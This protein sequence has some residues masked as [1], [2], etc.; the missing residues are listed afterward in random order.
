ME[1]T[2]SGPLDIEG[3]A[4]DELG[5]D[6][7]GGG[8]GGEEIPVC[9]EEAVVMR[10]NEGGMSRRRRMEVYDLMRCKARVYCKVSPEGKI[11]MVDGGRGSPPV[12]GM[13]MLMRTGPRSFRNQSAVVGIFARECGKVEGCRLMVAQSNNLTFCEQVSHNLRVTRVT[14]F[15]YYLMRYY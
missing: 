8:G 13:T 4:H 15:S 6:G 10:H 2:F 12:I 7:G 14:R 1:A 11:A 5:G 3:F 9:F